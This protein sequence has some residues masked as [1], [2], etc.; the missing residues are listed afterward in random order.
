M[1]ASTYEG[2]TTFYTWVMLIGFGWFAGYIAWVTK[3]DEAGSWFDVEFM[4]VL[5]A[6]GGWVGLV[7]A[8]AYYLTYRRYYFGK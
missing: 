6:W 2:L 5:G 8:V 1:K 7:T 3:S 4:R